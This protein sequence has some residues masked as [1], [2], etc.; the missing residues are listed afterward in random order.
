MAAFALGLI[1]SPAARPALLQALTGRDVVL[2]SRAAEALGLIG[3]KGDAPAIGEMAVRMVASARWPA[4]S[5][6][7]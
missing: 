2:Q 1:G 4:C 6:R 7:T 5:R 3:D